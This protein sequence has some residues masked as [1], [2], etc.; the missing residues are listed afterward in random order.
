MRRRRAPSTERE[1]RNID[2][3]FDGISFGHTSVSES[4]S[5]PVS[6]AEQS[7]PKVS[8]FPLHKVR[9]VSVFRFAIVASGALFFF[10]YLPVRGDGGSV[11]AIIDSDST[12]TIIV[13]SI[14]T[15]NPTGASLR[16]HTATPTIA[17][18]F[19]TAVATEETKW[20]AIQKPEGEIG[21]EPNEYLDTL[22]LFDD[23]VERLVQELAVA[24]T[25]AGPVWVQTKQ[26]SADNYRASR[27]K[28]QR[29]RIF[30]ELEF[31]DGV[32]TDSIDW[33]DRDA[34]YFA[35]DDDE[36]RTSGEE[37]WY[38]EGCRRTA[39]QRQRNPTCNE[40]HAQ[41]V[42]SFL[43]KQW[44][45][46]LG[47]GAYRDGFF[48]PASVVRDAESISSNIASAV[49]KSMKLSN[50]NYDSNLLANI[51]MSRI[52]ALVM[53]LLSASPRITNIYSY[54]AQGSI[55]EYC[56]T[57]V[58]EDIVKE[59]FYDGTFLPGEEDEPTTRNNLTVTEK[60]QYALDFAR[61]LAEMHGLRDGVILHVDVKPD[62][63]FR[64]YDGIIKLVDFNRAEPLLYDEETGQYC[65]QNEGSYYTIY[66]APE[67][68]LANQPQDDKADVFNY[69][70][71]IY[72]VLTGLWVHS[73]F[74]AARVREDLLSGV[75]PFYDDRWAFKSLGEAALLRIIDEGW[76]FDPEDRPTMFEIIDILEEALAKQID[77][78]ARGITGDKW[79]EYLMSLLTSS[80]SSE[81]LE[82]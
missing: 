20:Q 72:S 68:I 37:N 69:A 80:G 59:E 19:Y 4:E 1:D 52:D 27:A 9:A 8:R 10:Q 25:Q 56:P 78:E 23:K 75:K 30:D 33:K 57:Q 77:F 35:F 71:V 34:P 82:D 54:C 65:Q 48:I 79:K 41:D 61:P 70:S 55:T 38:L 31:E 53:D 58:E 2:R 36:F 64:G 73:G 51:E 76:N 15:S 18:T 44:S 46:Y 47:A 39:V 45:S 63:Y 50:E 49:F 24:L 67:E 13:G 14:N 16:A 29:Q 42:G 43:I 7:S 62:N 17:P 26:T 5:S 11:A 12:T 60:L 74:D 22:Q 28:P 40:M 81:S 32:E 6:T 3:P 21:D 66:R